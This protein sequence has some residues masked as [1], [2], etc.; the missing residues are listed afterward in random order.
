M[1]AAENGH[2]KV[3]KMLLGAGADVQ[4]FNK[5]NYGSDE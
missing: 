1:F 4:V 5:V 3:V 2:K